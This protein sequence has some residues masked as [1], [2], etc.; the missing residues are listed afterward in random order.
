MI[1]KLDQMWQ[2]HLLRMD[3]LRSDVTLRAVG[4]RDP[5]TEFKHE[6]FALFDELGRNLRTEIARSIFRFEI[7]APQQTL[8]QMLMNA[9]L[10]METNRSLFDDLQRQQAPEAENQRG[11]EEDGSDD[12]EQDEQQEPVSS[13]PRVGRNDLCPCGSGKKYK[14]CCQTEAQP[15]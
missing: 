12:D 9:G 5:L 15:S 4:Q 10:R 8:Q 2:E 6:A 13:G 1:R 7:I 11:E 3:H 14:K